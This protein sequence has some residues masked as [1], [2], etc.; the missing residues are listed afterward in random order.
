MSSSPRRKQR[1]EQMVRMAVKLLCMLVLA[2]VLPASAPAEESGKIGPRLQTAL[3]TLDPDDEVAVVIDFLGGVD[4]Q[5][6]GDREPGEDR[7]E[8][9]K[10]LKAEADRT[11]AAIAAILESRGVAGA[12]QLWLSNQMA[13]TVPVSLVDDLARRPEVER[14]KLDVVIPLA[15]ETA[16]AA[17]LATTDPDTAATAAAGEGLEAPAASPAPPIG[18]RSTARTQT[19]V[20]LEWNDPVDNVGLAGYRLYEKIPVS[21]SRSHWRPKADAIAGAVTEVTDLRPGSRHEY[22]VTALDEE[23]NESERSASISVTTRQRP[24]AYHPVHRSN[25]PIAAIVGEIFKYNVD[26]QGVPA[27]TFQLAEGPDTMKVDPVSGVVQ[28][29]PDAGDEG[30]VTATV[31]ASNSEGSD[32]HTFGVQVHPTG[33]DL[34]APSSVRVIMTRDVTPQGATLEWKP[35]ADNVSVAG[36]RVLAQK[37]GRGNRL[38]RVGDA[39]APATTFTVTTLEPGTGYRLWIQPY[40]EAGNAATVSG[41]PPAHITT[42]AAPSESAVQ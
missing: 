30:M 26:A 18:L 10:A 32:N 6:Y 28:W 16:G 9:I 39:S 20:T 4:L 25:K 2:V 40:D 35:A 5:R 19:T 14:I 15:P 11:Q 21:R 8:L 22:A 27:P 7:S 23:G 29:V 13:V 17:D 1:W 41:V 33:S 37:F 24:I 36:Y 3:D 34:V 42:R 31:R 38:F 12:K